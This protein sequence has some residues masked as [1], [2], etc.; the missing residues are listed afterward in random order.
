[1]TEREVING[2]L[3][4]DNTINH[5]IAYV[6]NIQKINMKNLKKVGNFIDLLNGEVDKEAQDLLSDLRDTRLP[7]KIEPPNYIK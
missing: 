4:V 6:R 7:T 2:I 1:M 3:N 5:C